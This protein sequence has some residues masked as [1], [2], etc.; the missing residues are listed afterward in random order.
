M[1]LCIFL[2]PRVDVLSDIYPRLSGLRPASL[3]DLTRCLP[4]T[5][6]RHKMENIK[7]KMENGKWKMEN[8]KIK[9]ENGKFP[10]PPNSTFNIPPSPLQL[11]QHSPFNIIPAFRGSRGDWRRLR[12]G[13]READASRRHGL[14]ESPPPLSPPARESFS[15]PRTHRR[16]IS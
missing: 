13:C 2:T 15:R 5:A 8:G 4:G 9:M 7:F 1:F 14:R 6:C 16:S 10:I 3:P 12:R 11:I